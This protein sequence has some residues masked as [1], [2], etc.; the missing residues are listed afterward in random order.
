VKRVFAILGFAVLGS[1]AGH[2]LAYELRYGAAAQQLQTTGAHA[3]FPTLAKTVLGAGAMAVIAALLIIGFAR[4]VAGQKVEPHSAPSF[5]RLLAGLY[6]VQ[7]ALFFTQEMLEGSPASQLMLWGLLGQL[8]VAAAGALA[9]RWLLARLS[10]ALA[11]LRIRYEPVLH[12]APYA[13][14]LF[15]WPI[16]ADLVQ[17]FEPGQAIDLRGP[18]SF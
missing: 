4:L 17:G 7:L 2:L 11:R 15:V 3:Y 5:L 6:T 1:Q 8:P 18:P 13:L 12:F 10:P 9:L 16:A 14:A